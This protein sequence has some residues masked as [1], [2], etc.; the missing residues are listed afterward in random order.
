MFQ[1]FAR[2]ESGDGRY[3]VEKDVYVTHVIPDE[4]LG[5]LARELGGYDIWEGEPPVPRKLLLERVRGR[6]GILCLLTDTID[7]QVISSAGED[8]KVIANYAVG[9]NNVDV[10]EATRRGVVVTNTPGVLTETTADLAWT[11]IMAVSRRIVEADGYVRKGKWSGWGPMQFLGSDVHGKTLGVVGA[12]RIGT[13]V[14]E[15]AR[16]FGMTVLYADTRPNER[17]ENEL[18]GKRVELHEL[19]RQADIVSVH[20]PLM[21]S[22]EHLIGEREFGMMKPDAVLVNT[23]RGAVLDEAAL[24]RALAERRIGGA[25]LDVYEKEPRV[26]PG[27]FGLSNCV[28]VPHIGSAT[29]ETRGRMAEMAASDLVAVL[30]GERPENPVNPEVLES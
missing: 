24:V 21:P 16:G 9:Y 17:I 11:L 23:S 12:G 1:P 4:G 30:R 5:L 18:A 27:L 15:R 25:G 3:A 6:K 19:L 26:T 22:T 8:L 20:V 28:L 13:A 29:R 14:A 10:D 7:A 2:V